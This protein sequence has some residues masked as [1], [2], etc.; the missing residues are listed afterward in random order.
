MHTGIINGHLLF[1]ANAEKLTQPLYLSPIR[2]YL[3]LAR[4]GS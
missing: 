2:L 3:N 4:L 1:Y